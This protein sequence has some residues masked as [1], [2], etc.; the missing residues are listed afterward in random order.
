MKIFTPGLSSTRNCCVAWPAGNSF[1]AEHVA[2]EIEDLG[3]SE[4][5]AAQSLVEHVFRARRAGRALAPRSRRTAA[6]VRQNADPQPRGEACSSGSLL[7]SAEARAPAR[8]RRPAP[9]ES[10]AS[11]LPVLAWSRW[12]A[13]PRRIGF[14]FPT[15]AAPEQRI[16]VDLA[17]SVGFAFER[18]RRSFDPLFE[19]LHQPAA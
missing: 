4:L 17:Y 3:C 15:C 19:I 14:R 16:G 8:T 1:D 2:E 13:A 7:G 18:G 12:L 11:G 5:R 6:A 10:T 9:D